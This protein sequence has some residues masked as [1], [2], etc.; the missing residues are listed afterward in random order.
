MRLTLQPE[1]TRSSPVGNDRDVYIPASKVLFEIGARR[2]AQ[3]AI[4]SQNAEDAA[5]NSVPGWMIW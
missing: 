1:A 2:A 5:V 3:T 4:T